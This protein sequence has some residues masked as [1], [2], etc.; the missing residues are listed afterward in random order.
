VRVATFN[1]LHGQSLTDGTVDA[2]RLRHD[3][4]T[5]DADVLGLQEVDRGQP[6]SNCLDEAAEAAAAVG[7]GAAYRFVPTMIGTPGEEWT[8]AVDGDEDR[9]GEPAYGIALVTRLPVLRWQVRRLTAAPMRSPVPDPGTTAQ[10]TFAHDEP[11]AMLAAV[12]EGPHGPL[13]VATAH[14]SFVPGWNAWQLRQVCRELCD[15][16]APRL[17]LGDLNIPGRV[18]GVLSG[19]HMLATNLPTY[20]SPDPQFQLDHVLADGADGRPPLVVSAD[21]HAMR[22]SDHR[23][24]VVELAD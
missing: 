23:A 11:R 10:L 7:G 16:P 18:A 13:T 2:D 19:W 17:L 12:V 24:L 15:L 14:L 21:T 20:P 6:R 4:A 22:I 3:I 8:A 5:L 1:L 9:R